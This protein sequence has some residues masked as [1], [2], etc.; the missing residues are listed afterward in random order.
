MGGDSFQT[1]EQVLKDELDLLSVKREQDGPATEA[2]VYQ[3]ARAMNLAGLAFSGGGIRSATFNLG[4]LQGLANKRGLHWFDY[5]STVS[6]GGYIGGWLSAALW[7]THPEGAGEAQVRAFQ[8]ELATPPDP[9]SRQGAAGFPPPESHPVRF[10]R[11]FSNYLTPRLGLSGDTLALV[12]IMLRNMVVMQML[13]VSLLAT[14][15]SL[16]LWLIA[17]ESRLSPRTPLFPA[18]LA[19]MLLSL[20][21][22]LLSQ[23]SRR[24]RFWDAYP[25]FSVFVALLAALVSGAFF[26]LGLRL[27]RADLAPLDQSGLLGWTIPMYCAAWVGTLLQDSGRRVRALLGMLGGALTLMLAL[28]LAVTLLPEWLG[29]LP[30]GYVTAFAPTAAIAVYSLVI[31]VHLALAGDALT[32]QQREWWAR[33]G[34]QCM[35]LGLAWTLAI[36]ILL[37]APPLMHAG[38]QWSVAGGG[39]WSLL[40]VIGAWAAQGGKTGGNNNNP[41]L[42]AAARVAPWVFLIGLVGLVAWGYTGLLPG[43]FLTAAVDVVR[44]DLSAHM[45]TYLACLASFDLTLAR[46]LFLVCGGVFL[47]FLAFVDLNLFSAHSFYR[48]RLSRTFLGASH[49]AR[50]PNPYTGFDAMDNFKLAQLAQQRPLHLINANL[51]I[52]GG[53]ELGWQTRRGASFTFTPLTCGYSARSSLGKSLGGYRPTVDYAAGMTLATCMAVSG[54][55]ASPNM[56]FHTSTPVAA[57]LTAFNLRLAR[58]CPNPERGQWTR[59]EPLFWSA[60]PLFSELTGEA[61]GDS[62]WVNLSDGGHFENLGLYELVR[63]RCA[64]IVVTDAGEDGE[65]HFDDLALAA[66]R[67]SVDFGVQLEFA[68]AEVDALRPK[69]DEENPRFSERAWAVGRLIYPDCPPGK[70]IYVKSCLPA[71]APIDIRQYRDAHPAFPHESTAD[72]WFDENQFE[73]YRHLGQWLAEALVDTLPVQPEPATAREQVAAILE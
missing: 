41:A 47:L 7:R 72:Q 61:K 62:R 30:A 18:A 22:A 49:A 12:A 31:T 56:G 73:A 45:A 70:V 63:R 69:G 60:G 68:A 21:L 6:G 11:R 55:A 17:G 20:L 43:V 54:A 26:A 9:A 38:A 57:L 10:L 35:A 13:L 48:N 2:D 8:E 25:N 32:E 64:L 16:M 36:S 59:R 58:W 51:N 3:R 1:F 33:A 23:R 66:R 42:E 5:L 39:L 71:R 37:F 44:P 28:H 52:S 46:L 65:Y 40:S 29:S 14:L 27:S 53:Q 4:F 19:L 67:L 50:S 24:G 34:G 15:F